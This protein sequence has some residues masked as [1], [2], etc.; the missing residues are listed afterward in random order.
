MCQCHFNAGFRGANFRAFGAPLL[1]PEREWYASRTILHRCLRRNVEATCRA[2]L[3]KELPRWWVQLGRFFIACLSM[4]QHLRPGSDRDVH[5]Q[6]TKPGVQGFVRL[7]AEGTCHVNNK[8]V[9]PVDGF[10]P[11]PDVQCR[12]T[13]KSL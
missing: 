3:L 13:I 11:E 9:R 12:G 1:S 2:L 5:L 7:V 4:N 8:V 6:W 10:T